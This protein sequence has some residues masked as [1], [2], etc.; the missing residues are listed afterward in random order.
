MIDHGIR[1]L[2][3]ILDEELTVGPASP[4]VPPAGDACIAVMRTLIGNAPATTTSPSSCSTGAPARHQ[5]RQDQ[6]NSTPPARR[7]R[8]VPAAELQTAR[9]RYGVVNR[10]LPDA[11][12][13][14]FVDGLAE[15]IAGHDHQALAEA[16]AL[17]DAA[18]LPAQA[19][20]ATAYRAFLA[21]AARL[22]GARLASGGQS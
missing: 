13:D 16:K 5:P 18:T 22:A 10:A 19:D 11:E 8:A 7:R 21:A 14:A 1:K 3:A 17:I 4:N 15:R 9:N 2:A 20:L 12:L 6:A